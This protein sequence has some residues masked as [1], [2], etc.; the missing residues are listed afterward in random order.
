MK[1]NQVTVLAAATILIPLG[2]TIA[3]FTAAPKAAVAQSEQLLL[4]QASETPTEGK[5]EKRRGWDRSKLFEQL[6]LSDAQKTEI[7]NIRQ[8]ARENGPGREE[9]RAAR[10]KMRELFAS[11]ASSDELRTQYQDSQSLRQEL[12]E[13][14][15]ETK[16]KIREVLTPE[17]R[18]K[19]AELKPERRRH[20]GGK[21]PQS[22][23]F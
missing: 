19:L 11:D 13:Q 23:T 8:Q 15:F 2:G 10:E 9:A 20:R 4:A 12:R 7:Q 21:G 1:F 6:D 3:H 22:R 16:L 14:R 17:Q 5:G 18:T